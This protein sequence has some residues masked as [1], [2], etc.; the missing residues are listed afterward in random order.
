[1][2][3]LADK[4]S[5]LRSIVASP[6][7]GWALERRLEYVDGRD[8]AAGLRGASCLEAQFGKPRRR[9][10]RAR[11]QVTRSD[12]S[13]GR[14]SSPCSHKSSPSSRVLLCT[15]VGY[16]GLL[17]RPFDP[18]ITG[19]GI[20]YRRACHLQRLT[21]LGSRRRRLAS[22]RQPAWPATPPWGCWAGQSLRLAGADALVP[23]GFN[24]SNSG[25]VGLPSAL[26]FG[27]AGLALGIAWFAASAI[28]QFTVGINIAAGS[29][30]IG[31]LARR[32]SLRVAM[33]FA[34]IAST[35]GL[36]HGSDDR[37]PGRHA[38]PLML[39]SL[40]VSLRPEVTR[41]G[42]A[43]APNRGELAG[44]FAI[45]LLVAAS[46]D[47]TGAAQRADHPVDHAVAI[48]N[49]LFALQYRREPADVAGDRDP[50]LISFRRCQ[51]L[52]LHCCHRLRAKALR[53]PAWRALPVLA[54]LRAT[55]RKRML[56]LEGIGRRTGAE[57]RGSF[58]PDPGASRRR[59]V[60][61]KPDSGDIRAAGA[62]CCRDAGSSF[63][64][65]NLNKVGSR[66]S[67]SPAISSGCAGWSMA[68]TSWCGTCARALE[69]MG[70]GAE[71][72]M[73]RNPRLIYCSVNAYGDR[74]EQ[75]DPAEP[76]VQ[77]F[78]GHDDDVGHAGGR[79]LLGTQVLDQ[80]RHVGGD[81]RA[82]G[83]GGRRRTGRG[84]RS[85]LRC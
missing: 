13:P 62:S 21:R 59:V 44:G 26:A 32:P 38:D 43:A 74:A 69:A 82:G 51:P 46:F 29:F 14:V 49:Y 56:P 52:L 17:K 23:A 61:S 65:I 72:L 66:R 31:K 16:G 63:N 2:L 3:K 85:T 5:N 71:A 8:V 48:F 18:G 6:P 4:T 77:A 7:A 54:I 53:A 39:L 60:R 68:P 73:A 42:R 57:S 70:L 83:A 11:R 12:L 84:R 20:G 30:A 58:A 36:R 34:F 27:D 41:L 50:D 75:L 78:S 28:S 9:G 45:G 40:G 80:Q 35:P 22:W 47:L 79:P 67:Q 64:A 15:G 55:R 37:D 76:I 25:N 19:A 1:M 81:R 33:A 10:S 24:V